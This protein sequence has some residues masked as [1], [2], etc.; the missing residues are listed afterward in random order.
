MEPSIHSGDW[1]ISVN[2]PLMGA[3]HHG[4]L[5]ALF[6]Y[7]RRT[8]RVSGLPGDYIKVKAGK[9]VRN[10]KAVL[11]PSRRQPYWEVLSDFPLP[12]EAYPENL[13]WSHEEA[14]GDRLQA[15]KAFPSSGILLFSP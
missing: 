6:G 4:E 8:A 7:G 15:G 10:G 9:L 11:E 13:R 1:I 12:S 5:I 3:V 2:A 14:Y